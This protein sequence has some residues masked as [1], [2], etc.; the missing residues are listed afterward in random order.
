MAEPP[1]TNLRTPASDIHRFKDD[2]DLPVI[3]SICASEIN[4]DSPIGGRCFPLVERV[5]FFVAM[6]DFMID[7]PVNMEVSCVGSGIGR[8]KVVCGVDPVDDCP[9][10][11]AVV[12]GRRRSCYYYPYSIVK[13]RDDV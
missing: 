7:P 10:L 8:K 2:R 9:G 4:S 1:R 5:S 13:L 12:L 6:R 3:S 11:R